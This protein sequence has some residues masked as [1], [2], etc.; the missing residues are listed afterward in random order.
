[1]TIFRSTKVLTLL[2]IAPAL[3]LEAITAVTS[4]NLPKDVLDNGVAY[5]T[6]SLLSWTLVGVMKNILLEWRQ[7]G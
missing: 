6:G 3:V 2:K 1:M 7:T 5:F 4:G